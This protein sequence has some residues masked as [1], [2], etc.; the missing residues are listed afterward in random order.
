MW[1]N[2]QIE[3]TLIVIVVVVLVEGVANIMAREKAR[4]SLTGERKQQEN[5]LTLHY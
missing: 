4:G 1:I 2:L 5:K 3:C